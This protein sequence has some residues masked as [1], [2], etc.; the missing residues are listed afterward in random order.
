M[1][2]DYKFDY[3]DDVEEFE[4]FEQ[5][6]RSYTSAI[7]ENAKFDKLSEGFSVNSLGKADWFAVMSDYH[8]GDKSKEDSAMRIMHD[9]MHYYIYFIIK[10]KYANYVHEYFDDMVQQAYLGVF[11]GMRVYDPAKG[12]PSTFMHNYIIR[13]IQEFIDKVAHKTTQHY[14]TNIKKIKKVIQEYEAEGLN[15]TATDIEMETKLPPETIAHCLN[16][17]NTKEVSIDTLIEEN[18]TLGD[19]I[20]SHE[21]SPEQEYIEKE[22][23]ETINKALSSVLDETGKKLISMKFG[24]NGSDTYTPKRIA[25]ELHMPLDQVNRAISASLSKLRYSKSLKSLR[26]DNTAY[27]YYEMNDDSGIPFISERDIDTSLETLCD[28]DID[29]F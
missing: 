4:D 14:S 1:D 27:G 19:T 18:I 24:L 16:I 5:G 23:I 25:Q 3:E 10:K 6:R 20:A 2:N 29:F 11:K 22:E 26:P 17:M 28:P 15:C 8:S 21:Q 9:H 7:E 13:E 12:Q